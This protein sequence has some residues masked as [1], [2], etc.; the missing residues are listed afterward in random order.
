VKRRDALRKVRTICERLDEI[1]AHPDPWP[2]PRPL[3]AQQRAEDAWNALSQEEREQVIARIV[4]ALDEQE[5]EL[6]RCTL[7]HTDRT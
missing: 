1:E 4:G 2:G 7:S 6:G 5:K 3:D